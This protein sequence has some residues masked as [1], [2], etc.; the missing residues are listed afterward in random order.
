M[1]HDEGSYKHI[2]KE[3]E[4][5]EMNYED[6]HDWLKSQK[7][8][9]GRGRL[10]SMATKYAMGIHGQNYDYWEE[11]RR[12]HKGLGNLIVPTKLVWKM[13]FGKD[14]E[15]LEQT[16]KE[17]KYDMPE[18]LKENLEETNRDMKKERPSQREVSKH[19]YNLGKIFKHFEK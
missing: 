4:A 16:M 17:Q 15:K 19:F 2:K 14:I 10:M 12:K 6:F 18:T 5:L 3:P 13:L 11:I 1:V 9:T 8:E 7:R